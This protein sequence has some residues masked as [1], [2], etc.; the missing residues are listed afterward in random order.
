VAEA[1][2]IETVRDLRRA[3]ILAA[4]RALV[5]EQGLQALTIGRL[6]KR[7]TFSRGVI[8]YHFANKDEI[9]IGV[10]ESAVRDI[11]GAIR[12]AAEATRADPREAL[13]A[14]MHATVRGYVDNV[15][16]V[17][18]LMGFWGRIQADPRVAEIN[19]R[20]YR[21][22]RGWSRAL[23]EA[24]AEAGVFRRVDTDAMAAQM[25][26]TVIGIARQVYFEPR[27]VDPDATVDEA[28]K[29]FLARLQ[30]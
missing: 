11:D 15:E 20:L 4:A 19:A 28:V 8:T 24:G 6:E 17:Q 22:Y 16:A 10:L 3:Q 29:S 27:A 2:T 13:R 14:T 7:L 21:R 26:G 18:I 30:P 23:L 9:V 12:K 1:D 5:A 25:V